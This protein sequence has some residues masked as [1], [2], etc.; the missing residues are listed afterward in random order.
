MYGTKLINKNFDCAD[1]LMKLNIMFKKKTEIGIYF[2]FYDDNNFYL[3]KLNTR[4]ESGIILVKNSAGVI[5]ELVYHDYDF[6]LNLQYRLYLVF[7]EKL[8]S[9]H[10]QKGEYRW[11]Q[12][13]F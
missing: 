3:L 6:D 8:I 1:A 12:K 13:I 7:N 2:R 11:V 4:K 10:I 9:L 5:S